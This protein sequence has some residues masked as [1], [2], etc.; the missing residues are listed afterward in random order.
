MFSFIEFAEHPYIRIFRERGMNMDF[1]DI[2]G[3][4]MGISNARAT[5]EIGTAMLAKSLDMMETVGAGVI[6]LIERSAME[7]SVNPGIGGNIDIMV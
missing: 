6:N 2:A 7:N 5:T 1:M 4:S 3:M